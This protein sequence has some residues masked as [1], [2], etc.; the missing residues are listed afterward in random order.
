VLLSGFGVTDSVIKIS[1]VARRMVHNRWAVPSVGDQVYVTGDD[2]NLSNAFLLSAHND[3]NAATGE[4]M[5]HEDKSQSSVSF[6]NTTRTFSISPTGIQH[7][8]WCRGRRFVKTTTEILQIPNT[9]GSYAIYYDENG[10]LGYQADRFTLEFQTPTSYVYWN[11]TTQR[12]EIFADERHGIVLDW[13]THE[14]LH[15]TRGASLANGFGAYGFTISGSGSANSD[16][17]ISFANG[18][19]FDEDLEVSITHSAS[20]VANTWQQRIQ[21]P[22]YIPVFYRSGTAWHRDTATSYPF[23]MGTTYPTYNTYSA[24]NWSATEMTNHKFSVTW[25]VATNNLSEPVIGIMGQGEYNNIGAAE[26]ALWAEL[27]LTS[28]PIQEMR[29]LYKVV[30]QVSSSYSNATKTAIRGVYDLRTTTITAGASSVPIV[31]D[32]GSLTGLADDDHTQYFDQ[33]R[34]DARYLQLGSNLPAAQLT[35]T[36]NTARLSG[37]YTGITGI[38]SITNSPNFMSTGTLTS[39]PVTGLQI[40]NMTA[41]NDAFLTLHVSTDFAGYFGMGGAENDLVV[42]GFSYGA[43]RYRVYHSGNTSLWSSLS[44]TF[45]GLTVNNTTTI[46]A[47]INSGGTGGTAGFFAYDRNTPYTTHVGLFCSSSVGRIYHSGYGGNIISFNSNSI[48]I[49]VVTE[50]SLAGTPT[51]DGA[52]VI[53]ATS[54]GSRTGITIKSSSLSTSSDFFMA[55]YDTANTTNAVGSIFS[56]ASTS[57]TTYSTTSDYRLKRDDAPLAGSLERVMALRPIS[58]RWERF[59]DSPLEEGFFAH[60]VQEIVPC[61]AFGEKDAED[62]NGNI[63]AQQMELSRLVPVLVGAVQELAAKVSLLESAQ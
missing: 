41:G 26:A 9:T 12:A 18:T 17:Q 1:N 22:A 58:Y 4:P 2:D 39:S 37:S 59:A 3:D 24:P 48:T 6:D 55:F 49:P 50:F 34:G 53:R 23:K 44:P 35:G 29:P 5:G 25:V 62:E 13:Q 57:T 61:A 60:E 30:F 28:L 7:A 38:G 20:P 27:D 14:Y 54:D 16:A 31:L 42:G 47:N 33:T 19:F 43:N 56:P 32:H 21:G 11:A 52:G 63:V 8:V 46:N 40:L 45:S 36:V 15:R 10:F 51:G